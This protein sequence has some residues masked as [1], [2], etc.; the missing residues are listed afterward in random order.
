MATESRNWKLVQMHELQS[1]PECSIIVCSIRIR[2]SHGSVFT[3]TS[4]RG[5]LVKFK[6]VDYPSL[7]CRA[8]LFRTIETVWG[9]AFG[10]L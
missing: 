1:G 3:S 7:A 2:R 8:T 5:L 10:L 9:G 4:P 6:L